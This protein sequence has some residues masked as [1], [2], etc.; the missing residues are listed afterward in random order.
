LQTLMDKGYDPMDYRHMCLG[1]HYRKRLQF[2]WEIL[3]GARNGFNRLKNRIIEFK[4]IATDFTDYTDLMKQYK[5]RFNSA[6]N[7]DLNIPEGLAVLWEVIRDEKLKPEEKLGLAYDFDKVF[8]LGLKG[9]EEKKSEVPEE[10]LHLVEERTKAKEK[11]DFKR[12]DEIRKKIKEMG[13]ELVDK[14]DGVEV[15][16]K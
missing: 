15:K 4:N 13:F 6:V 11:K 8:G 7:E 2:T 5:Q 12:A 10:V 9:I 14:K 1:T 16:E 3:D